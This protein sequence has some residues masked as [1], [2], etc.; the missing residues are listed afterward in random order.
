M[1]LRYVCLHVPTGGKWVREADVASF[2]A[3]RKHLDR[4]N[5]ASEGRWVYWTHGGPE[6][7]GTVLREPAEG[8]R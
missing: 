5:E 4:W 2:A 8:G 3:L 7:A 1:K 6:P